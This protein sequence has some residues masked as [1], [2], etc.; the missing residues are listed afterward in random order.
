MSVEGGAPAKKLPGVNR[1]SFNDA[2]MR[3]AMEMYLDSL[4]VGVSTRV[5]S[6]HENT[7]PGT[8]VGFNISFEEKAR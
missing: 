6:V 7:T 1:I 5:I 4:L 3:K 2:T 8:E